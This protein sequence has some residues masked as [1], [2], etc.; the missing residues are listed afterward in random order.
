MYATMPEDA[1]ADYVSVLT[2]PGAL[3][4]ALNYYRATE[5]ADQ[6]PLGPISIPTL[7]V[8]STNDM[9]LGREAA[10]AT[11][12]HI[13]GPYRFEVLEG[14]SHWIPED[15]AEAFSGFLLEHL[16]ADS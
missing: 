3:T 6:P 10:E 2:Q 7:Y 9:A 1:A 12:S 14:V 16:A 8:W 11:G 15:A 4:G 5:F 13:A